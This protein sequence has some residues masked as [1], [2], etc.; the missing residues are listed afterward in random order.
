MICLSK[1]KL[2]T[3]T[4]HPDENTL[5]E[6]INLFLSFHKNSNSK[7]TVKKNVD[8][9]P[10]MDLVLAIILTRLALIKIYI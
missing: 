2:N 7:Y 8:A 5:K 10:K 9:G 4:L 6:I 3:L 1:S